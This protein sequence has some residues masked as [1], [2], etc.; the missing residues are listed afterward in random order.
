MHEALSDSFEFIGVYIN[1]SI[2]LSIY[3]GH[4]GNVQRK[5]GEISMCFS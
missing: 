4:V 5:F 2:Y 3:D 1:K